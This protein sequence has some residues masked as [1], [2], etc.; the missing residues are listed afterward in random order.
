MSGKRMQPLTVR[1]RI[2]AK[3]V[4]AVFRLASEDYRTQTHRRL[5]LGLRAETGNED[6]P[7]PEHLQVP[8]E[9]PA[10]LFADELGPAPHI[11][12]GRDDL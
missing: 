10:G 9:P 6:M 12:D 3:L 4:T 2:V 5:A 11:H 7:L 8:P 1:D